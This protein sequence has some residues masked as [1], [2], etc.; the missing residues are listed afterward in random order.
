MQVSS[1]DETEAV[2]LDETFQASDP[3]LYFAKMQLEERVKHA[4]GYQ[5]SFESPMTYVRR[6]FEAAFAPEQRA[7]GGPVALW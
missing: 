7:A 5:F 2:I 3:D 1:D 6:F 4:L